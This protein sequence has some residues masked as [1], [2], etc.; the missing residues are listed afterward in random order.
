MP[1]NNRLQFSVEESIC[2]QKGQEV[3][4]LL[5]ISLDP[6]ITVQEV[7]DYVSIRGSLELTG[8]YNIDQTRE[9]AELPATSRFVED[10][11]LKGDGSAELT[12]CF[13]VD[14]TIPKDKVNHLNDVFVFIDAFDYQ[15]TDA[16]MLTIQADLAI[17][18]LLNVSGEAGEEEPRTMPAAV[19]PEEELEPA[20]RSPS[21]DEEQGKEEEFLIQLDRSYEEQDEEQPYEEAEETDTDAEAVPIYQSFLGDDTEET[22][23]FFTASLSAAER[24]KREM[25]NP[26][27]AALEHPEE[28][29]E[30]KREKVEAKPEEYE[31]KREKVEAKPE[32]YELKEEKEAKPEEHE[33]IREKV[34]A[35]PEEYELKE[36]KEAKPEEYELKREEAEAEPEPL[37]RAY[38]TH[39]EPKETP[40]YGVPPLLEEDQNDR[41]PETFEVEVTQKAEAI[42]EEEEAG[43]TIEIPEYSFHEQTEPEEERDEMPAA[44]DQEVS[45]KE[46]DNALYLTKLFTKQ[47]EEEFT[48]MRMCIVQQNDT[49]DLLCE[50]YDINVQQLI[51]MNSLSLDEELKEGQILY[52]PDYQSSH[53]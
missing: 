31:L 26:K 16:R 35:K 2:F 46:N 44:D 50:R 28:E 19:Q 3:S 37:Q 47:G 25:E 36:E 45:A 48:R 39:D 40:F 20:F 10:V 1:Q 21:N 13:P 15:L 18:G 52:I 4:E 30:L 32:E 27:D 51:R 12:H 33:L 17:E 42:D 22:K 14:I 41:E 5:S 24:T 34:E 6:D 43:H 8:E 53:A 9:Y 11:K 38:Q 29:Y 49:I 23:P 7:N